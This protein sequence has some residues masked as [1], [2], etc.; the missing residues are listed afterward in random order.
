MTTKVKQF[1][2][3]SGVVMKFFLCFIYEKKEKHAFGVEYIFR[4]KEV[5]PPI[6]GKQPSLIVRT[7]GLYPLPEKEV[8]VPGSLEDLKP[9]KIATGKALYDF[10][11]FIF[12]PEKFLSDFT[13]AIKKYENTVSCLWE[14]V[15]NEDLE[16]GKN[17]LKKIELMHKFINFAFYNTG[18]FEVYKLKDNDLVKHILNI[19]KEAAFEIEILTKKLERGTRW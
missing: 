14:A 2:Y 15:K 4:E 1:S 17:L 3:E 18:Y 10:Y 13:V 19:Y 11:E 7:C 6:N 5:I 9:I 12:D 16:K 8:L